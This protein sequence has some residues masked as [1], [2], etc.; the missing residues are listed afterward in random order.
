M[1]S[2]KVRNRPAQPY[3]SN[4]NASGY[5][6][7]QQIGLTYGAPMNIKSPP[8]TV[9]QIK[10]GPKSADQTKAKTQ[11]E[12]VQRNT[13]GNDEQSGQVQAPTAPRRR[14][15]AYIELSPATPT[16]P[17][18]MPGGSDTVHNGLPRNQDSDTKP[19]NQN[20]PDVVTTSGRKPQFTKQ[21]AYDND[22]QPSPNQHKQGQVAQTPVKYA[23]TYSDNRGMGLDYRNQPKPQIYEYTNSAYEGSN[24]S[25]R[26]RRVRSAGQDTSGDRRR[27]GSQSKDN[28]NRRRSGSQGQ[29]GG[30]RRQSGSQ[31]QEGGNRRRSGSQ[32]KDGGN[33]RRRSGSQGQDARRRSGSQGKDQYYRRSSG[34]GASMD[35]TT[36]Q[37]SAQ[38]GGQGQEYGRRRRSGSQGNQE[39]YGQTIRRRSGSQGKEYVNSRRSSGSAPRDGNGVQNRSWSRGSG[40]Y[41]RYADT[42]TTGDEQAYSGRSQYFYN[43]QY[44]NDPPELS[45][46]SGG[47]TPSADQSR[48]SGR[49]TPVDHAQTPSQR[50][51]RQRTRPTSNPDMIAASANSVQN[52]QQKSNNVGYM[53]PHINMPPDTQA[54]PWPDVQKPPLSPTFPD[55]KFQLNEPK[56]FDSLRVDTA[57]YN[58]NS[59]VIVHGSSHPQTPAQTRRR[60][61]SVCAV[62]TPESACTPISPSSV[63]ST[64]TIPMLR[65][66]PSSRAASPSPS[67]FSPSTL[68]Y[69]NPYLAS[70]GSRSIDEASGYRSDSAMSTYQQQLS[71][72]P[73]SSDGGLLSPAAQPSRRGMTPVRVI[74]QQ[75]KPSVQSPSQDDA[76]VKRG[77]ALPQIT[78]PAQQSNQNQMQ[79]TDRSVHSRRVLQTD[80]PPQAHIQNPVIPSQPGYPGHQGA[81]LQKSV[82]LPIHQQQPTPQ[83]N[84]F[85]QQPSQI[86]Q[87]IP[88]TSQQMQLHALPQHPPPQVPST[89]SDQTNSRRYSEPVATTAATATIQSSSTFE[90]RLLMSRRQRR[91]RSRPSSTCS[92]ENGSRSGSVE[93]LAASS[94]QLTAHQQRVQAYNQQQGTLP[95][96]PTASTPTQPQSQKPPP[97]QLQAQTTISPVMAPDNSPTDWA[98]MTELEFGKQ[99]QS[100]TSPKKVM[101][102]HTSEPY[103][104]QYSHQHLAPSQQLSTEPEKSPEEQEAAKK[105]ALEAAR[106]RRRRSRELSM[107]TPEQRQILMQQPLGLQ[108]Q[109]PSSSATKQ[110]SSSSQQP[111]TRSRSSSGSRQPK[112]R[113][114]ARSFNAFTVTDP[115]APPPEMAGRIRT[116]PGSAGRPDTSQ[117]VHQAQPQAQTQHQ[118]RV[119]AYNQQQGM[120][121]PTKTV[122]APTQQQVQPQLQ[123]QTNTSQL[124]S[125]RSIVQKQPPEPPPRTHYPPPPDYETAVKL[126]PAPKNLRPMSLPVAPMMS[127]SSDEMTSPDPKAKRKPQRRRSKEHAKGEMDNIDNMLDMAL[128]NL[129]EAKVSDTQKQS[130]G[131]DATDK[132]RSRRR[133]RRRDWIPDHHANICPSSEAS[134][135]EIDEEY[136]KVRRT[137]SGLQS[138]A[139]SSGRNTPFHDEQQLNEEYEKIKRLLGYDKGPDSPKTV[140]PR[141]MGHAQSCVDMSKVG[142]SSGGSLLRSESSG[143]LRD[144]I[145]DLVS[146]TNGHA[147]NVNSQQPKAVSENSKQPKAAPKQMNG[148]A[149]ALKSLP[150]LQEEVDGMF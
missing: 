150:P 101:Y 29:D 139:S 78:A 7:V 105:A 33:R 104:P 140:K 145:K 60:S 119:Q 82:Q 25:N 89:G 83:Y 27:S 116:R 96:Q 122:T 1:E 146:P 8:K 130:Y 76:I 32:G 38:R 55:T 18:S 106:M 92:D 28:Q 17:G 93:N 11:G 46:R 21:M 73:M 62:L 124:Q 132:A 22:L 97:S 65:S 77:P 67:V 121:Q 70:P 81:H 15:I 31:G 68:P 112:V 43:K 19:L 142:I 59:G 24:N 128:D 148:G 69:I 144:E 66:R 56:G 54:K 135:V 14:S 149:Q 80:P 120:M 126:A 107:L 48:S 79:S 94:G 108:Q 129:R 4:R 34:H 100:V 72:S 137:A 39:V 98:T 134:E 57:K 49:T 136:E 16:S 90:P 111:S 47:Q 127:S 95:S 9:D 75:P 109:T 35:N 133:L 141:P 20:L 44:G 110:P 52:Q 71:P 117:P 84:Q 50:H 64:V 87:H 113:R 61:Y 138:P 12:K 115:M 41:D 5:S 13:S 6:K 91:R 23:P 10:S 51:R 26:G 45:S 36:A 37:G 147:P 40:V 86:A 125:E 30:N 63:K 131:S 118:Q 123:T 2:N 3:G 58:P 74:C 42:D 88:Q 85:A 99:D 53:V 102:P 114:R 103:I 143:E